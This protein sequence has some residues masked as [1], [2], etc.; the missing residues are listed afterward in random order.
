MYTRSNNKSS[1]IGR[2]RNRL[3]VLSVE[4]PIQLTLTTTFL[5]WGSLC[6]LPNYLRLR[7]LSNHW[8]IFLLVRKP[9][10]WGRGHAH[11]SRMGTSDSWPGVL[12]DPISRNYAFS[13]NLIMTESAINRMKLGRSASGVCVGDP[14]PPCAQVLLLH[15][16]GFLTGRSCAVGSFLHG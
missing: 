14:P 15:G 10:T 4:S 6:D 16:R 5:N 11:Y 12:G 7:H 2:M 3:Y 1:Q 8:P 9:Q 13:P